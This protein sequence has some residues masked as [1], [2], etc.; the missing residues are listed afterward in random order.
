MALRSVIT[1]LALSTLLAAPAAAQDRERH[2]RTDNNQKEQ[3]ERVR[4]EAAPL[5]DSLRLLEFLADACEE[6]GQ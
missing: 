6:I 2:R 4:P 3:T 5:P 1:T